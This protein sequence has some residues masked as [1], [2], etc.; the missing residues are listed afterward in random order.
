MLLVAATGIYL[1]EHDAQ[2][3]AFGSIPNSLWWAIVTIT[4]LGYGDVTPITTLGRLFASVT[5]IVGLLIV[6]I[7]TGIV[8]AGF[9]DEFRRRREASIRCPNCGEY[10]TEH[11]P[12]IEGR[13]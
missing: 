9:F 12:H 4:T 1:A 13:N 11:T 3:E 6:A 10:F 5:V 7:P 2:P 8:S